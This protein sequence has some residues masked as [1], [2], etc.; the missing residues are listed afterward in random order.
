MTKKK[1]KKNNVSSKNESAAA[2]IDDSENAVPN[3]TTN[4]ADTNER[5][6]FDTTN[7]TMRKRKELLNDFY[8]NAK[9]TKVISDSDDDDDVSD[10]SKKNSNRGSARNGFS[11][12]TKTN[13][14]G[15]PSSDGSVDFTSSNI[16]LTTSSSGHDLTS[17]PINAEKRLALNKSIFLHN[18]SRSNGYVNKNKSSEMT[19]E[20][21]CQRTPS[22]VDTNQGETTQSQQVAKTFVSTNKHSKQHSESNKKCVCWDNCD[23]SNSQVSDI[24]VDYVS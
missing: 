15:N 13:G 3:V 24:D 6:L 14:V 5:D 8:L 22:S 7:K 21:N 11:N 19:D 17:T 12:G 2:I 10:E 1:S 23:F 18:K 4:I 9:R 16:S 20:I